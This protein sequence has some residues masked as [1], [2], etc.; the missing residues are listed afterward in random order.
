MDPVVLTQQ[1]VQCPSITPED[2]GC[3]D[4]IQTLLEE[5]GFACWRLPFGEV[6]NLYARFGTEPPHICFA[7][8]TDVVPVLQEEAWEQHP[9]AGK[10]QEDE[11]IGR[12]VV[13]MK[14]AIGSFVSAVLS[15]LKNHPHFSREG[16]SISF[17]LT[18]D[19]EGE[20][21]DGTRRVVEW[22]Q[23]RQEEIDLCLV[24]EP[25]NPH[26]VG[27]MVK[28]GRRGS[29]N[30]TVVVQGMSGHVAYP[31][32]SL[33]PIPIL[34]DYLDRVR[35]YVFDEGMVD[36]DPTHLEISTID[37][38]NPTSNMIPA[39][40]K[41]SFNIR[42]NPT[43]T[44]ELL[45][46]FL[47]DQASLI[48]DNI[49]LKVVVSGEAFYGKAGDYK[50]LISKVI[51]EITEKRPIFSTTGG[52]SDARFIRDLC[53][54]LEFGLVSQTAH[55]ANERILVSEIYL[56]KEIY[57]NILTKFFNSFRVL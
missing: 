18:S 50:D 15:F 9:F 55:Q 22:L 56:L 10:I 40:A 34:L 48:S 12:G 7:G 20:A 36:F 27:E 52:T 37:V 44:G 19:E 26:Y 3:L 47:H 39:Q 31:E 17:I 16:G 45:R 57:E 41:A 24:G 30:A 14:G 49:Q 2:A 32:Q 4:L 23:D 51:E 54:V 1:L 53:P 43:Y 42:F 33:N 46:Q 21:L 8:H 6:D 11:L 25:T 35:R 29:L 38:E 28:I 5:A 13:D